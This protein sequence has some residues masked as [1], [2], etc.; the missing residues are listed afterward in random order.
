M[1]FWVSWYSERPASARARS[2][3]GDD[4]SAWGVAIQDITLLPGTPFNPTS[5]P[6]LI[7]DLS[8]VGEITIN[9]QALRLDVH[10][11]DSHARGRHVLR[12]E[13]APG[14]LCV[15]K[16]PTFD[17]GG[18]QWSH[19]ECRAESVRPGLRD[20]AALEFCFR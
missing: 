7:H 11:R 17:R 3:H 16:H 18:F 5:K 14:Q 9:P 1:S 2:R 12:L 4:G 10:D 6:I 20:R 19:H 8:G 15:R 13:P